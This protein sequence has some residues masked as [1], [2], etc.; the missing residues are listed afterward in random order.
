MVVQPNLGS[1]I[2][3][4]IGEAIGPYDKKYGIYPRRDSS[5]SL[6]VRISVSWPV[7]VGQAPATRKAKTLHRQVKL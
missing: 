6:A 1:T 2:L 4:V 3:V 7:K 5:I